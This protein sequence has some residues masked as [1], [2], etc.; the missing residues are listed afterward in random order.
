MKLLLD[1]ARFGGLTKSSLNMR[2][3]AIFF[4]IA[5][6][7]CVAIYAITVDPNSATARIGFPP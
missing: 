3:L 1:N 6:G 5:I 4:C 7:L 2:T